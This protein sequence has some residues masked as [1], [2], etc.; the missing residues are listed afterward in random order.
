MKRVLTIL[1]TLGIL[2]RISTYAEAEMNVLETDRIPTDSGDVVIHPIEHASFV[3]EWNGRT[4]YVDP[5][6]DAARYRPFAPADWI[7]LTHGHRDHLDKAVIDA[8]STA[9]TRIVAPRAVADELGAVERGSATVL[10]NDGATSGPGVTIDAVAMYNYSEGRTQYHPK[11]KGNGYL[12]ALGGKRIYLSGDTEDVAEMRALENIDAAFLCMNVPYTMSVEQAAE[13]AKA[14]RPKIVYPYHY[15]SRDGM[16]DIGR[17]VELVG[18]DSG[19]E[20]R[21]LKWY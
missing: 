11:G 12:V 14:F 5:V 16:S 19:I 1:A 10:A 9:A 18:P 15:R 3:M 6:G 2:M 4:I 13:A 7:L 20:V 17:F 8:V 21:L